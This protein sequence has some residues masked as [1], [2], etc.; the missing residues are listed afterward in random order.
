MQECGRILLEALHNLYKQGAPEGFEDSMLAMVDSTVSLMKDNLPVLEMCSQHLSWDL[1]V[2]LVKQE[3]HIEFR[4][5][6]NRWLDKMKMDNIVCT[7]PDLMVFSLVE[8]TGDTAYRCILGNGPVTLEE[9][10]PHLHDLL[11]KIIA[12]FTQKA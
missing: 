4:Q 12:M 7:A 11:R 5:A 9:Y 8:V 6:Y 10:L 1:C 3:E 2:K